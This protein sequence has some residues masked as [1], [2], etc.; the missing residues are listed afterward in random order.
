MALSYIVEAN[1]TLSGLSKCYLT[2]EVAGN[3]VLGY[4]LTYVTTGVWTQ[5]SFG[6][7]GSGSS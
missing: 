3:I 1:P 7:S 6:I 2:V 4:S 5:D